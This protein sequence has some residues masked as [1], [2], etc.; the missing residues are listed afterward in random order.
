MPRLLL[1]SRAHDRNRSL[2]WLAVAW[3]EYFWLH[4]PGDV[5]G[6]PVRHDDEYT[7]FLVDCYALG[8]DGRRLYDSV[9]ISRPKGCDKSGI[10]A[11]LAGFEAVGPCRVLRETP[12]PT[13]PPRFAKG[14]EVYQDPWGLGFSY[15]YEPGEPMGRPVQTPFI[16]C[17]ATEEDQ[18]G[19]VYDSIL[20]NFQKGRLAAALDR[21][22][23][24]ANSRILLPGGG[25]I[26]PS[27]SASA[28]KDG[29]KETF[30]PFD[31]SHL[32]VTRELRQMY[33]TVSR[34]LPKRS[35]IAE[36]WSLETTTMYDPNE[37]S[38]ARDTYDLAEEIRRRQET[39]KMGN[40]AERLL[41][42][43][44]WGEIAESDIADREK[45]KAAVTEAYG[46]AADV[47]GGWVRIE[48]IVEM[49]YDP[50]HDIAELIRYY[51]NDRHTAAGAFLEAYILKAIGPARD[52]KIPPLQAGDVITLGFDGSRGRT[53]GKVKP[54]ATALVA[55]RLRD[56]CLF[57]LGVW[58]AGPHSAEWA[59]WGPPVPL[60]DALVR[61]TFRTYGV[62]GFYADPAGWRDLV[63]TWEADLVP[64]MTPNA[65]KAPKQPF[66]RWMTGGGRFW[67]ESAI[68]AFE[69]AAISSAEVLARQRAKERGAELEVPALRHAGGVK[70]LEHLLNAR[71]GLHQGRLALV[72]QSS[73]SSLKIDAG[74]ASVLAHKAGLDAIAA[75]AGQ[76]KKRV[77]VQAPSRL[78]NRGGIIL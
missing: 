6:Q 62:A 10:A 43:H 78:R 70:I 42:D 37:K 57:E 41:V 59:E 17:L 39:G 7:G 48:S 66:E 20:Y 58:E 47:N 19:L 51:L 46:E 3:L 75:G 35:A 8:E 16:R 5:Q 56:R 40:L 33:K 13:S 77:A 24:A 23:D 69:E 55:F 74:I 15:V 25:E 4:G 1:R 30:V 52:E 22:D 31:E 9:F 18:A 76:A 21:R 49:F 50:R 73:D 67:A 38:I 54:D 45:L 27:T 65:V 64:L 36:T 60:I 34:N 53:G 28:S 29:G 72:K 14:G 44:R 61:Q 12:D 11:R 71:R 2:G 68:E 63:G 26:T 32:Y